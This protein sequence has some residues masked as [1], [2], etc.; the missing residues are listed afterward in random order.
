MGLA[1]D[2]VARELRLTE[3]QQP[4]WQA[5]STALQESG[6]RFEALCAEFHSDEPRTTL[7]A[8]EQ[9]EGATAAGLAELRRI[10][11]LFEA[12]YESL[13]PEQRA[14]LDRQWVRRR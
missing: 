4:A 5:L 10:Q 6:T 12:F 13:T 11:P 7:A 1:L 2:Y 3:A 8:L 9:A 14:R